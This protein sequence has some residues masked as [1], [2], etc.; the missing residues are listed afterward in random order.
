[1][2]RPGAGWLVLV[3][4][5][6]SFCLTV[7]AARR[8]STT[9]DEIVMIASGARGY[10]TGR[11]GL[12]IDQPP[13]MQYAYGLPIALAQPHYPRE[14]PWQPEMVYNYAQQFFWGV[15]NDPQRL[16]FLARLVDAL[17]AVGLIFGV[18]AFAR[19]AAGEGGALL[20][21]MLVAFL[22]DVLAHGGVAYNDVPVTLAFFLAVWAIDSAVRRPGIGTG[23]LAGALG[24]MAV[25]IKFSAVVL[26]PVAVL[27]ILAEAVGRA[28]DAR[29][30]WGMWLAVDAGLVAGYLTLVAIYRGD[31]TLTL[32]LGGVHFKIHQAA[33]GFSPA[34]AY[35]LGKQS[36]SGFWYFYPV[37][38][39]LKTPATLPVLMVG[40]AVGLAGGSRGRPW[41]RWLL[42]SRL[43]A[44]LFGL[45]AYGAV[46]FSAQLDIGFRHAM[47]VLPMIC[48][49]TAAGVAE[50]W[51]QHGRWVRAFVV[52]AVAW[53]VGSS[54]SRYPNFLAYVSAFGA[55]R[56]GYQL[57]D[58]S[59]LDWGQGLLQLR[60]FL[61]R[62]GGGPVYLSYFGSAWPAGYGIDY[63]A[64]PSFYPLP[65]D[66]AAERVRPRFVVIS[67]TNLAGN[68]LKSD[69]FSAYRSLHPYRVVGGVLYIYRT[70]D[71]ERAVGWVPPGDGG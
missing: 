7:A 59:S 44:P 49:L 70:R 65:R 52:L 34:A 10:H 68:Y 24:A 51:R 4:A 15:G 36:A 30:R 50:L 3:I 69:P 35:F 54:V 27:L 14:G 20:A 63:V 6:A 9:F 19:R 18:W 46:L 16:A 66:S 37:A 25:G 55:G 48:V 43:R 64:L 33:A 13:V 58:D 67:A 8:T 5:A 31:W 23:V 57:L 45:L 21:A 42:T 11:W 53:Y 62:E 28:R 56:P 38:F 29:W 1:M 71:V 47:P 26:A 60:D 61:R 22:P 40:A 2:G 12:L 17:V 32:L 41:L 39:L